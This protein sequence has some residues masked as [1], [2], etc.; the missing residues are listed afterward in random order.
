MTKVITTIPFTIS[1]PE[2]LITQS[3]R[4]VMVGMF[5]GFSVAIFL[6]HI[7]MGYTTIIKEWVRQ[8]VLFAYWF[9]LFRLS[10]FYRFH[11]RL[12]M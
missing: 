6:K 9:R 8:V 2:T 5:C 4:F 11:N 7:I 3:S 1:I 10:L 12:N